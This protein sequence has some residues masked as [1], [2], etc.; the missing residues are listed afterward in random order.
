MSTIMRVTCFIIFL[1][2]NIGD[3]NKGVHFASKN[4]MEAPFATSFRAV[5]TERRRRRAGD[6]PDHRHCKNDSLPLPPRWHPIASSFAILQKSAA[7]RRAQ[8]AHVALFAT[9]ST[10]IYEQ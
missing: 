4:H 5:V 6:V 10:C 2:N 9:G 8:K 7:E 3:K 1:C